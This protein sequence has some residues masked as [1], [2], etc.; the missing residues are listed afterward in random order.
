MKPHISDFDAQK[1]R[2]LKILSSVATTG[3]LSSTPVSAIAYESKTTGEVLDCTLI[4]RADGFRLHLL[5]HNKTN[6]PLTA[7][8]FNSQFLRFG[9]ATLNMANAFEA[10]VV[11]PAEDRVMVRLNIDAG[12]KTI[13]LDAPLNDKLLSINGSNRYLAQGTYIVN[14]NAFFNNGI[15]TLDVIPPTDTFA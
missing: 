4:H 3:L 14:F 6:N 7:S 13:P 9:S 2:T 1:R 12:L 10:T 15:G 11:I 8:Q 5:M